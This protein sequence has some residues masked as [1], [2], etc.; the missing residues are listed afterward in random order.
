[1]LK[2]VH[3]QEA[4]VANGVLNREINKAG[5]KFVPGVTDYDNESSLGRYNFVDYQRKLLNFFVFLLL[6][7]FVTFS[8]H[9]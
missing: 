5:G 7:V 3:F 2:L 9:Y 4:L 6:C 8:P 1:M